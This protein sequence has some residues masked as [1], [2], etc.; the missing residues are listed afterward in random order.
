MRTLTLVLLMP[1]TTTKESS[2]G[3]IVMTGNLSP[4]KPTT[5]S[6]KSPVWMTVPTPVTWSTWTAI[7]RL[8]G[9]VSMLRTVPDSPPESVV[10]VTCAP[11]LTDS[12]AILPMTWDTSS[13]ASAAR[14]VTGST[15]ILSWLLWISEPSGM[16]AR[17]DDGVELRRC[18]GL[19]GR[20]RRLA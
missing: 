5:M 20:H 1:L 7:E 3:L 11:A 9:G 18:V 4:V 15:S 10:P 8:P 13:K 14:A 17:R 12:R 2:A 6:T 16:S 19:V